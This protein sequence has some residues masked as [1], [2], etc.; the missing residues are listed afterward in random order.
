MNKSEIALLE[1]LKN[2]KYKL[3]FSSGFGRV[4]RSNVREYNAMLS[5]ADKNLIKYTHLETSVWSRV[6]WV[7]AESN[8]L[9]ES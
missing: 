2:S 3:V 6:F 1:K 7:W 8:T 9:H 4:P 5:L